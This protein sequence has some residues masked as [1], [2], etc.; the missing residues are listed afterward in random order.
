MEVACAEGY[1]AQ[2]IVTDNQTENRQ[3][4]L[5][6]R[7][8]QQRKVDGLILIDHAVSDADLIDFHG[9]GVPVVLFDRVVSGHDFCSVL[10]DN[11]G[12]AFQLVEHLNDLGHEEIGFVTPGLILPPARERYEGY[13]TALQVRNLDFR[14]DWVIDCK[15]DYS[16]RIFEATV[17]RMK[18]ANRLP[19]AFIFHEDIIAISAASTLYKMGYRIPRDLSIAGFDNISQ[20]MISLPSLTTIDFGLA[21]RGRDLANLLFAQIKNEPL[22]IKCRLVQSQIVVRESTGVVPKI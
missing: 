1:Q 15:G 2:L 18:A 8:L 7:M 6:D 19:R 5:Y 9:H 13:R 16:S 3:A 11:R 10:V 4:S 20:S 17:V 12:G 14:P 22:D 21:D